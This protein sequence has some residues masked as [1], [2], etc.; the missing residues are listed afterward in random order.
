MGELYPIERRYRVREVYTIFY[1]PL[2]Y[3]ISIVRDGSISVAD[4]ILSVSRECDSSIVDSFTIYRYDRIFIV[5]HGIYFLPC[6]EEYSKEDLFLTVLTLNHSHLAIIDWIYLTHESVFI[7]PSYF[8]N[9]FLEN[10]IER[11]YI[12]GNKEKW[13]LFLALERL[14]EKEKRRFGWR[15]PYLSEIFKKEIQEIEESFK[16]RKK[17]I[18]EN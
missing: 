11:Y 17:E 10:L 1:Y 15:K 3:G 18:L 13:S 6:E 7:L 16:K 4:K 14:E 8:L 2:D 12:S 5:K 9:E